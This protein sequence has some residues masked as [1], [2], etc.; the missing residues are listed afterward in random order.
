MKIIDL[1]EEP[2]THRSPISPVET[3]KLISKNLE[4]SELHL[5]QKRV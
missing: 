4:V 3:K 5:N 1:S 2:K